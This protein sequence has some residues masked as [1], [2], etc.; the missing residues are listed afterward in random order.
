MKKH[1]TLMV[2]ATVLGGQLSMAQNKANYKAVYEKGVL[3]VLNKKKVI[4]KIPISATEEYRVDQK[5]FHDLFFFAF[6]SE[7]SVEPIYVGLC[8]T[9]D[10]KWIVKVNPQEKQD[11]LMPNIT[12]MGSCH[13]NR[14]LLFEG[15]TGAE[16]RELKVITSSGEVNHADFYYANFKE[17]EWNE[18]R[19]A[20]EYYKIAESVPTNLP[21]FTGNNNTW[22]RKYI[23][24]QG[25]V[26]ATDDF[27]QTFT[28]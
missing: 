15:G 1:L 14:Y 23:W 3:Q 22:L 8:S 19:M 18:S 5:T 10:G 9:A 26:A 13:H 21:K 27:E 11:Y 2:L 7:A 16:I 20:F 28:L 17:P 24:K 12:F 6:Y 4:E 25:K